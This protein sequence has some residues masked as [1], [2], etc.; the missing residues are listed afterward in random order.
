MGV[1]RG[2]GTMRTKAFAMKDPVADVTPADGQGLKVSDLES[3][4][5]V[6]SV[7]TGGSQGTA[8]I[9]FEKSTTT[10]AN[11]SYSTIPNAEL[12]VPKGQT[13][14]PSSGTFALTSAATGKELRF[15]FKGVA[16]FIRAKITATAGTPNY[17]VA[18]T[19]VGRHL[20]HVN[21]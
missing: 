5:F 11:A 19:G 15:D 3:A 20:R 4:C 7:E 18:I 8:T 16:A 9:T 12:T 14:V 1:T 13:E 2:M 21:G 17:G 6:V 10:D